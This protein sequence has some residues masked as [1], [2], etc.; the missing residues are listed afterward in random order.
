MLIRF[1]S[2]AQFGLSVYSEIR[3]V[4]LIT[5]RS[6]R[7][8]SSLYLCQ[9]TVMCK[10]C[11]F[12]FSPFCFP[13]YCV[14]RIYCTFRISCLPKLCLSFVCDYPCICKHPFVD[15]LCHDVFRCD[16][17]TMKNLRRNFR[18][19]KTADQAEGVRL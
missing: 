3:F 10:F 19:T 5:D 18:K 4:V 6:K 9:C 14:W 2:P 15:L 13:L 1:P 7:S 11:I 16:R 8:K 17:L 12:W